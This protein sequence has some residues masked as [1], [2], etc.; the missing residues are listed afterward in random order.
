MMG[1]SADRLAEFVTIIR[2]GSVSRAARVLGIPRATL[3]RRLNG[4]ERE[5]GVRLLQRA[6]RP[7]R[8]T[9]A[10]EALFE[11]AHRIVED[12]RSAWEAVRM[13][14]GV[15][16]G[17]LRVSLP[18][19]VPAIHG[20]IV[21]FVEAC[22]EV[23]LVVSV[24]ARHVDL[25][26]EGVDVA[27]RVGEVRQESVIA[28][29]IWACPV[30]AVAAPGYVARRGLPRDLAELAEHA[31]IT[32][33]D[34]EGVH[35]PRWP[36]V[37]GGA[38]DVESALVCGDIALLEQ[39]VRAGLGIAMFPEDL[40]WAA[41]H[42]GALV[43][44]LPA[45]LRGEARAYAVYADREYVLPQMRAFIDGLVAY[46]ERLLTQRVPVGQRFAADPSG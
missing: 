3:S 31:C 11:R 25:Q 44:V 5:L 39:A 45:V 1:P 42:S 37:G 23:R 29:R 35:R 46:M 13:L 33:F 15:P 4:L 7:M 41:L 6:S 21:E 26:A 16:R 34:G 30:W 10:G 24:D 20:Y 9:P 38:V 28:R 18:P 14:D 8:L 2:E 40:G 12:T 43:R 19:S 17:L 32:T 36:T 27:I 22:P